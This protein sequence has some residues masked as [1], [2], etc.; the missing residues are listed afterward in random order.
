M[1]S[2]VTTSSLGPGNWPL[3]RITYKIKL[4]NLEIY[5]KHSLVSRIPRLDSKETIKMTNLLG[6][7]QRRKSPVSDGPSVVPIWVV[8]FHHVKAQNS[9]NPTYQ[10][11]QD[12]LF[13]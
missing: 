9:Q 8:R 1:L 12:C 4:Q 11:E 7:T 2:L 3:M 13:H 6:N 10:G 5:S